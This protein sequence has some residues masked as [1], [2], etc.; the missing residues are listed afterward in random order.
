MAICLIEGCEREVFRRGLC[1]VCF[2]AA[3]NK[4]FSGAK[5]WKQL[6]AA[7]IA[8][9]AP[10]NESLGPGLFENSYNRAFSR[11]A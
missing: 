10:L 3:A 1:S 11:E 8:R 5:T 2:L 4:V 9:V 6:E 7:G